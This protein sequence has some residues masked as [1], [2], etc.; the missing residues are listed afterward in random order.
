MQE[1]QSAHQISRCPGCPPQEGA[2]RVGW[3]VRSDLECPGHCLAE[4]R[5]HHRLF[6][7]Q[8][9]CQPA[10]P[11]LP[12]TDS[13]LELGQPLRPV[14]HQGNPRTARGHGPVFHPTVF[15][16]RNRKRWRRSTP[17]PAGERPD[18]QNGP[19]AH[20]QCPGTGWQPS[21]KGHRGLFRRYP[22]HLFW[23]IWISSSTLRISPSVNIL[24][25]FLG[26]KWKQED[27]SL[28]IRCV[29]FSLRGRNSPF[30]VYL[31]RVSSYWNFSQRV[32]PHWRVFSLPWLW[33]WLLEPLTCA[34]G[35][36]G[37]GLSCGLSR[38]G[39][40]RVDSE[41]YFLKKEKAKGFR[42]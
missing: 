30:T 22:D 39:F 18:G 15:K 37:G 6:G 7:V 21:Q 3:A 26:V 14:L 4:K 20:K 5:R 40:Q 11:N 23:L 32:H 29:G 2:L 31:E 17:P 24:P 12:G 38:L 33:L 35:S 25:Y 27:L 9:L 10:D 13:P 19:G 42:S 8:V 34:S 28:S 1:L 36:Q 16:V 41:E